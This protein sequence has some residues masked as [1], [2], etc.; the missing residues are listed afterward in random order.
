MTDPT[1]LEIQAALAGDYSIEAELG[2]GGMGTVY[3]A[4]D[5]RLDRIVA[6]KVLSHPRA[7]DPAMRARFLHEARVMA[8]LS[9]PNIIPVHHVGEARGFA[10][11]VMAYV[12]GESFARR[13]RTGGTLPA[14]ALQ[15]VLRDVAWALAY[16]HANGIVHRDVKPDNILVEADTGRALVADFGIAVHAGLAS[17]D[18]GGTRYFMSPEQAAGSAVDGR[19]DLYSLGVVAHLAATG[20]MPSDA[21]VDP[22]VPLHG[23]IARCLE[24]RP[25]DRFATAT[26]LIESLDAGPATPTL[27]S[28]PLR[29]WLEHRDRL[30]PAYVAWSG[31]FALGTIT[32][33]QTGAP[34]EWIVPLAFLVMP[35]IP[36][37]L[38]FARNTYRALAAGYGLRDLR[39]AIAV[40]DAERREQ[41]TYEQGGHESAW[42]KRIRSAAYVSVAAVAAAAQ[43]MPRTRHGLLLDLVLGGALLA[44]A[45]SLALAHAFEVPLFGRWAQRVMRTGLRSWFWRS[46]LGALAVRALAPRAQSVRMEELPTEVALGGAIEALFEALP[47]SHQTHLAHLPRVAAALE[48]RAT[49]ARVE[50][51]AAPNRNARKAIADAAGALEAIRLELLRM[52]TADASL[53]PLTTMLNDARALGEDIARLARA[54]DE[55]DATIPRSVSASDAFADFEGPRLQSDP[56]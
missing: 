35:A 50:H 6:I 41:L 26:E 24:A 12:R 45:G 21:G 34:G 2:R 56:P 22:S 20:R 15:R 52:Q 1:L 31:L 16:A 38:S 29:S 10:F 48:A 39:H 9:H 5:L 4:R 40:R 53:E 44:A 30:V 8:R 49:R 47:A 19:S 32:E 27:L 37:L 43:W 36:L 13:L 33:W 54:R 46:P 11:F 25:E 55:V 18:I 14:T 28:A 42:S 51:A 17:G 23:I 3:R 7:A